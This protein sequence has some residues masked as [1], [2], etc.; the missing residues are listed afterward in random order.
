M[1]AT[2]YC[3]CQIIIK[4][5]SVNEKKIDFNNKILP[6]VKSY[7]ISYIPILNIFN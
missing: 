5:Q 3:I 6:Y 7:Y 2:D 1:H 4:L